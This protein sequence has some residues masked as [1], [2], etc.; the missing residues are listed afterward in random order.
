M[1]M[2]RFIII[3][4]SIISLSSCELVDVL[5]KRPPYQADLAGAIVDQKSVELALNGTYSQL[6]TPGFDVHF[7]LTA[8]SFAG[9]TMER[10]SFYTSGNAVYFSERNWPLLGWLADPEWDRCYRLI[11]NA[12]LLLDAIEN[13]IDKGAFTGNRRDEIIGELSFLK[14]L[15]YSRLMMR[16]SQYWDLNSPLGLI[17]REELPTLESIVK[18]RSTVVESYKLVNDL[19]DVAVAKAPQYKS[20]IQASSLAAKALKTQVMFNMGRYQEAITLADEVLSVAVLESTY[21]NVFNKS[22]ET[23]E[24]IFGRF[25]GKTEAEG[26]SVRISAFGDGKWGPSENFLTLLG[27]DPRYS[28][29]IRDG[30][31]IVWNNKTYSDR[32]TIRK[33][34]NAANNMPIMYLRTAEILLIKAEALYR[35][36]GSIADSYAPIKRLRERAGAAV[37]TPSTRE[38]LA[39]AIYKEWII[40]LSFENWHEWFANQRFGKLLQMNAQLS[41]ALNI[42]IAKGEAA[43]ATYMQRIA[44]RRI[45][46]IPASET[47]SNPVTQNPGY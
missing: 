6:P 18:P 43:G 31:S 4:I 11:K 1:I 34:L 14:A 29:I 27:N 36:N 12:N 42:E 5:D 7:A 25:F 2:K 28:T 16:Y 17:I 45:M 9:G 38:Q 10:Q 20:A 35:T 47:N 37:V 32:K 46:P 40:E 22:L 44:D 19:L 15:C 39:E 26:T 33:Y 3:L 8:G 23:K 30:V 24:L 13:R 21:A 41:T